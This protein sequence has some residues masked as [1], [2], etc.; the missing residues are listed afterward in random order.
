LG[1]A[2][3][4][5]D[6]ND[7]YHHDSQYEQRHEKSKQTEPA[8]ET[9]AV[10]H[11][12]KASKGLAHHWHAAEAKQAC[13]EAK[14]E[15]QGHTEGQDKYTQANQNPF[16]NSIHKITPL[17]RANLRIRHFLCYIF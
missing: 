7:H 13:A 12:G 8:K 11:H 16:P 17:P 4:Q 1:A 10:T 3:Q 5:H 9:K 2:Q 14:E 15:R 6:R